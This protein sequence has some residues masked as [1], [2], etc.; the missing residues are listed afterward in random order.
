M[1]EVIE[2]K[3]RREY[4]KLSPEDK[5]AAGKYASKH[6]VAKAVKYFKEKGV[7][8]TNVRVEKGL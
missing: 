6:S 7:K 4:N 5:A 8:K 1:L 3:G 2:K